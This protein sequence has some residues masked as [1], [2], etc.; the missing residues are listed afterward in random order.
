MPAHTHDTHAGPGA[1][2]LDLGVRAGN[3]ENYVTTRPTYGF[4][5]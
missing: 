5:S 2:G 4:S 1:G 3:P